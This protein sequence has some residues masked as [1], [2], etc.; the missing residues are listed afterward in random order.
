MMKLR[1]DDVEY[2]ELKARRL[3]YCLH[4]LLLQLGWHVHQLPL[5]PG[6]KLLCR[7]GCSLLGSAALLM[8]LQTEFWFRSSHMHSAHGAAAE[9]SCSL[10]AVQVPGV[11][12]GRQGQQGQPAGQAAAQSAAGA[13]AA[14]LWARQCAAR[15]R[16]PAAG[17]GRSRSGAVCGIVGLCC[18]SFWRLHAW[19][20]CSQNSCSCMPPE[21]HAAPCVP[22][23]LLQDMT[24]E[25]LRHLFDSRC[26][27]SACWL[28]G[29]G[30]LMCARCVHGCR[31]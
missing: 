22:A 3:A 18:W 26:A 28:A 30:C 11:G 2:F 15:Q 25:E 9:C 23:L 31:V 7:D 5:T 8:L 19:R 21:T 20:S 17:A 13:G 6:S 24:P 12:P 29:M 10:Y 4:V 16:A 27:H 14:R 1:E